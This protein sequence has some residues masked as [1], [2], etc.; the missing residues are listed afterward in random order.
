VI[1]AADHLASLPEITADPKPAARI[2][3]LYR[4]LFQRWATPSEVAMGLRFINQVPA[5]GAPLP[6][7]ASAA[8]QYGWGSVD[9]VGKVDFH[10]LK[11]FTGETWQGGDAL[12]DPTLGWVSI[13]AAGGHPGN[14]QQHA[15]IRRWIAPADGVISIDGV[16]KHPAMQGDGVRGRVVSSRSGVLGTWTAHASHIGTHLPRVEVRRGDAIDF[17]VDCQQSVDSD[18]FVWTPNIRITPASAA[19]DGLRTA[20]TNLVKLA[21]ITL[22][23][24]RKPAAPA[25]LTT[26]EWNGA[27]DFHGPASKDAAGMTAWE[28]YA[29]VL[30]MTNEFAFLD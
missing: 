1:D 12:P 16:L 29:Q 8:W 13:T 17:V 4:R 23:P 30:M 15:A 25:R 6:A 24:V 5:H 22:A 26:L 28:K 7:T 9:S 11:H 2:Q 18:S 21:K 3:Q 19:A 20:L 27:T 10:P 14:D